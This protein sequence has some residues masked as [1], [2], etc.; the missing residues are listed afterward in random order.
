MAGQSNEAFNLKEKEAAIVNA[1]TEYSSNKD[2]DKD[3]KRVSTNVEILTM[4]LRHAMLNTFRKKSVSEIHDLFI[5]TA[6]LND[7]P[8]CQRDLNRY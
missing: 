5:F 2:N 8:W 3:L 7:I 1:D 6:M 4:L